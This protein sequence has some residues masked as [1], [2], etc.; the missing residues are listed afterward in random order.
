MLVRKDLDETRLLGGPVFENPGG[1]GAPGEVAVTLN[2]CAH[3]SH[4]LSIHQ[5]PPLMPAAKL[6]PVEPRTRTTPL[7]MYSQP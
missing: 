1:A 6:R 3:L 7:V 2:E 5:R 4:I